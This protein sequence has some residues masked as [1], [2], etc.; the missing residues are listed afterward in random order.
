MNFCHIQILAEQ[1]TEEV[2]TS[3]N[4]TKII[5][6]DI[7]FS[8]SPIWFK[9]IYE[10]KIIRLDISFSLSPNWFKERHENKTAN[11]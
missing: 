8:L 7:S 9:E 4:Q 1:K 11:P 6:L 3:G 2:L 5:G 10:R